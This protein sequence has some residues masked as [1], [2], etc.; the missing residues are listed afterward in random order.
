MKLTEKTKKRL[1]L[2]GLGVVCVALVIAISSQFKTE[3]PKDVSIQPTKVSN[4]VNPGTEIP[5]HSAA[6]TNTP[7][8]SALPIDPTAA[9]TPT[10]ERTRLIPLAPSRASSPLRPSRKHLQN[11]CAAG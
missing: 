4:A 11:P 7:E 8:V 6:P 1:I 3:E 10:R 5:T 2:A 9:P